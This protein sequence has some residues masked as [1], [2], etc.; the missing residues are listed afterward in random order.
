MTHEPRDP[1]E[2]EE[3][4]LDDPDFVPPDPDEP[5]PIELWRVV[6]DVP[7]WGTMLLLLG[8]GVVFALMAGRGELGDS[9]ANVARGASITQRD[10]WDASWRLLAST[11]LHS[12]PAHVLFNAA[13]MLIYGPTVERIFTRSS[14]WIVY[15]GGG[16]LASLASLAWRL[17]RHGEGLSLSI[18]ASGA[19]FALGGALIASA[20]RLRHRLAPGRAR[21]LG[22][23]ILFLMLPALASGF[24]KLGTDNVAHA[25]GLAAGAL[26]GAVLPLSPR[27]VASPIP[28]TLRALGALSA[29][30]LAF[31]LGRVLLGR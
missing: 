24:E 29:L 11:F 5:P 28:V 7:P 19:I 18:G 20:V 15:A 14:F 10:A 2:P 17:S 31:S 21:A 13:A 25:A 8:W 16:A 4:E 30:A 3:R 12:G 23:A 26:F 9:A 27:L 22:A 6:G 1:T